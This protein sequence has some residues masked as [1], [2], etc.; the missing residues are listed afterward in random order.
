MNGIL[1][2]VVSLPLVAV[3]VPIDSAHLAIVRDAPDFALRTQS[4]QTLG[5]R[6]ARGAVVLVSFIFTTCNGTCPATTHRM[7]KIQDALK[8]AGLTD[9]KQVRLL[10]ITLDPKRDTPSA[11]RDYMRLYDCDSANWDFLTGAP[12]DVEKV[13]AQWG[14][15]AKPAPDNQIDHPSRTF[16]VDKRGQVREIYDL[17]FLKP[18][19]VVEDVKALL[20]EPK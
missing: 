12:A 7:S 1:L 3:R 14:M 20:H 6:D 13:I 9:P 11:L 19:W 4:G 18:A 10:S 15:W 8:A 5:M 2:V 17:A 16:L